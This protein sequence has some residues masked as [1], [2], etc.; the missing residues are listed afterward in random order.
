MHDSVVHVTIYQLK[1]NTFI[2]S[3]AVYDVRKSNIWVV[4]IFFC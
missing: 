3:V 2:Y 1:E 4:C